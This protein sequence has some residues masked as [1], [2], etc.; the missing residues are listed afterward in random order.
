[1]KPSR[2]RDLGLLMSDG[3]ATIAGLFTTNAF[4]AAP[5]EVARARVS[6]GTATAVAVNSGQANAGT[7]ERGMRDVTTTT[8]AVADALGIDVHG[9]VPCSTGV[10]GEPIHMEEYLS[11]VPE[12]TRTL[13]TH[14]GDAFAQ[15]IMTTDTVPKTAAA[16]REG[17]RVGGCAK[18]VG[19]VSPDL[20]LATVLVF[21]TTDAPLDHDG[22]R[23]LAAEVLE[24]RLESLTVDGCTST[25]D[26]VLLLSSGAAG[27][28]VVTPGT[29]AWDAVVAALDEVAGSLTMQLAHDAEG[30]NHVMLVTVERAHDEH[31]ART[32]AKAVADSLLVK[33]AVFGGDPNPGRILQAVG[34]SGARFDPSEVHARLG[35]VRVIEGGHI[36]PGFLNGAA[37]AAHAAIAGR[38]V[39]ITISLGAG[40]ASSTALGVDLSYG[41]V[42]INAEYHT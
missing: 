8:T 42:K 11:A 35:D 40:D 33:T 37:E 20:K 3:D 25:N 31:D 4:A 12:L 41:Y 27:G 17:Y 24:P 16:E 18:G 30:G 39:E 28:P 26:T 23:R 36:A 22:V 2:R 1:M 19:M 32:V 13:S 6:G 29:E 5:V 34:A 7:G 15:A 10:I 21:V 14:G 38:E 9:V